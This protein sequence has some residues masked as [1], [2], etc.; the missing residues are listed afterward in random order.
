MQN[1]HKNCSTFG[2]Q[3]NKNLQYWKN[4]IHRNNQQTSAQTW[5][6]SSQWHQLIEESLL[7]FQEKAHSKTKDLN[8]Q[9][10]GNFADL[11]PKIRHQVLQ[12]IEALQ[13]KAPFLSLQEMELTL[14][15]AELALLDILE[16]YTSLPYS[17]C[18]QK[19]YYSPYRI[20][21]THSSSIVTEGDSYMAKISLVQE[22][23]I[24]AQYAVIEED[25]L[26]ADASGQILYKTKAKKPG[27]YSFVGS[28]FTSN[29]T[30]AA[31]AFKQFYTVVPKCN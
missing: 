12:N 22:P 6:K 18:L 13:L 20:A 14:N 3:Y 4:Q 17:I 15:I 7:E 30:T 5:L 29:D 19:I 25:T 24:K 31:H 26:Y 9:I 8:D 10:E 11:M 2:E 1:Q 28:V 16:S 21:I 27:E 23:E